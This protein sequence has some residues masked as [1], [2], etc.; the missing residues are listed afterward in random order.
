MVVRE[1][2]ANNRRV[3]GTGNASPALTSGIYWLASCRAPM[4]PF[5]SPNVIVSG[6]K[7]KA[8]AL[9]VQGMYFGTA[10]LNGDG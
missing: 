8:E 2:Q 10:L 5:E 4:A 3:D 7:E 1:K 6:F 9:V